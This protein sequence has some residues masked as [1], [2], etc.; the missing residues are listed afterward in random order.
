MAEESGE[1]RPGGPLYRRESIGSFREHQDLRQGFLLPPSP[2]NWLPEAH[3]A[4]FFLDAV[5]QMN[6]DALLTRQL[7]CKTTS[8]TRPST[9]TSA[10]T[11]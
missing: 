10:V 2:S 5:E 11:S 7:A 8:T 3:L 9:P 4:W 6:I 1:G